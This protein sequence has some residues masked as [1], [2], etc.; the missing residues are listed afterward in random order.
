ME[1]YCIISINTWK[2]KRLKRSYLAVLSLL[3][4]D[5]SS[6]SLNETEDDR[7]QLKDGK[8]CFMANDSSSVTS[9]LS[10]QHCTHA[11]FLSLS[12]C[13]RSA[14]RRN[15]Q[16]CVCVC[17]VSI[18]E[19]R[20]AG[21]RQTPLPWAIESLFCANTQAKKEGDEEKQTLLRRS[22]KRGKR[23]R[24]NSSR[25]MNEWGKGGIS[26]LLWSERGI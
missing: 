3:F 6:S 7:W 25:K 4:R 9:S 26:L 15:L 23:Y 19:R 18:F 11:F 8:S 22:R 1:T 17:K 5:D 10:F 14:R 16:N 12:V 13:N 21:R 2:E 20:Q 24:R